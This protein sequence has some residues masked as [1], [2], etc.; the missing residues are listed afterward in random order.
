MDYVVWYVQVGVVVLKVHVDRVI[1][2]R[3]AIVTSLTAIKQNF[4][5][6]R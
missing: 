6:S 4:D 1:E 3:G 2:A 5:P